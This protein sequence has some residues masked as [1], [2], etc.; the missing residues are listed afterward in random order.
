MIILS[1]RIYPTSSVLVALACGKAELVLRRRP[2]ISGRAYSH[3]GRAPQRP[4][5]VTHTQSRRVL[6]EWRTVW[7]FHVWGARGSAATGS[8]SYLAF[9]TSSMMALAV[10]WW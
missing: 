2:N 7:R 9:L 10:N 6:Q 4:E 8:P 1:D 5:T 3:R